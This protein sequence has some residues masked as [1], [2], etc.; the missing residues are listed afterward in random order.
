MTHAATLRRAPAARNARSER[1]ARPKRTGPST[2]RGPL[3][4]AA[5]AVTP[6]LHAAIVAPQYAE[7]ILSGRKVVELRFARA[8][9]APFGAVNAGD[10]VVFRVRGGAWF[11]RARVERFTCVA[12]LTGAGL[13]ALRERY[14]PLALAGEAFWA[15]L[16]GSDR[17]P[18]YATIVWLADVRPARSGPLR[19]WPGRHGWVTVRRAG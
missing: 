9:R 16:Q 7:A 14:E 1:S 4:G 18:G 2:R 3:A 11:A 5:G 19:T 10:E 8:R 6:G 15:A 13:A 17:P 12:G